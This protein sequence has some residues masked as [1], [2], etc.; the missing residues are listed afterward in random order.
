M[1]L[2]HCKE[3]KNFYLETEKMTTTTNKSITPDARDK[4]AKVARTKNEP[5]IVY[6][7]KFPQGNNEV[8]KQLVTT[9]SVWEK[10]EPNKNVTFLAVIDENGNY[11]D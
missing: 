9:L 7:A 5:A 2:Y 10:A 1:L 6:E 3:N 4:A 11:V 8:A